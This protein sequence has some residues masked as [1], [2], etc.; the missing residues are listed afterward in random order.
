MRTSGKIGSKELHRSRK[1]KKALKG[2]AQER[3]GLKETSKG[4]DGLH[5]REGS[6]TLSA[7][8]LKSRATLFKRS[9]ARSA[10][11]G[12]LRFEHAEG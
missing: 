1:G 3:W 7:G 8:P 9:F 12:A 11:K 6:Q 5:R 10:K 4:R 2:E